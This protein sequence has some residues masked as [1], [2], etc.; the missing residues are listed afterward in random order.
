MRSR[1]PITLSFGAAALAAS[2]VLSPGAASATAGAVGSC[3]GG[4][5]T[6]ADGSVDITNEVSFIAAGEYYEPGCVT[7]NSIPGVRLRFEDAIT[8]PGWTYRVKDAG[9]TGKLKVSVEFTNP[10]VPYKVTYVIQP[11]RI[12]WKVSKA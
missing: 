11:G 10:A 6:N 7:V 12:D 4:A 3:V 5:V 2:L 1:S 9:G 8:Y